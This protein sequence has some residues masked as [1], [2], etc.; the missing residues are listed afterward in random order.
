M[1]TAAERNKEPYACSELSTLWFDDVMLRV[2]F[3]MKD[4]IGMDMRIFCLV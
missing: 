4:F 2:P 1:F 3:L